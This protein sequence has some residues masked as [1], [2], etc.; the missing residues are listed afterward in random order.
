MKVAI[1]APTPVPFTRGGAERAWTGLYA[2][3][4]D[5]GHEAEMVKLPVRESTLAEV[6]AGYRAFAALDLDHFDVV[7]SSK[8]P[9]WICPHP[10]HVLWMFHPLRGLYDTYGHFGIPTAPGP[11]QPATAALLDA[12]GQPARR[13][14]VGD[15]LDHLDAAVAALGA[16]H[17]DLALPGPVSRLV[18][19][20]LDRVALDPTEIARHVALSRTV[21]TR[22]DYLPEGVGARVAHAPSDLVPPRPGGG[23]R[24][25]LFTASRLDHPKRLDLLIRAMAHVPGEVPLL[26]G[27]TGPDEAR[28]RAL[29]A[30]DPRIRFVGFVPDAALADLYGGALAVPF[31]PLDEDYGLIAVEAMAAG[32]PVVTC[33]DSGGPAELVTN[34]ADGLVVAPDPVALGRALAALVTDPERAA[35]LGTAAQRRAARISWP[36]VIRTL[37]GPTATGGA[38]NRATTATGGA[39]NGATSAAT[40]SVGP[41]AATAGSGPGGETRLGGHRTRHGDRARVVVTTTFRVADRGHGGQLRSYHLY[42]SLA[43]HADVEIVSLTD[44]GPAGSTVL[45]PG[46]VETAVPI[47]AAQRRAA[48]ERTLAVGLPVSDLT[49]GSE[50]ALTPEY[51]RVLRAATRNA[52]VVILAE[53]YLLPA[54]DE[55]GIALPFVYDAFNVEADLKAEVLPPG[56]AGTAVYDQVVAVERAAAG[57]AAAITACSRADA[58]A[59]AAAV[60]RP[61]TDARVVPNGTDCAALR[62]PSPGA[63][64]RRGEQWVA[65]YRSLDPRAGEV[66]SLAVFFGSWHP[67]NLVAAEIL[68]ELAAGVPEVLLVLGGRHGDAFANRPAPP[69][70]VFVGVVADRERDVLLR[71]AHVA[72]NPMMSGSGTNLKVIEYL[73]AG[74]PVVTT[75]V[76]ARGIDVVDGKHL[77]VV[78]PSHLA[79]AIRAVV[80]D[81]TAAAQRAAAG[82]DLVERHYDWPG[83]GDSLAAVVDAIRRR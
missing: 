12:V 48:E 26:I 60:G 38:T 18:V 59:L 43:R 13:S 1:V 81:P 53:P 58:E 83:L 2:A 15:V 36:S 32:T 16:D 69:N 45:G 78:S 11:V 73:A 76:G 55:A 20:W 21:A 61:G 40:G 34:G 19:R 41:R 5:A 37:L 28:L 74:A 62:R 4:L 72:L 7:I 56:A 75:E 17:P 57:R 33:T 50:I 54:L 27:G 22:A 64:R 66:T 8:Y 3:L 47:S 25:H 71:A 67:P 80:A 23:P 39:T 6:A 82:R 46:F 24:S 68:I 29:A 79:R 51:L 70:V 52:D 30:G 14:A 42:G 77:L 49:A 35:R 9:A 44:G 10:R 63:R 65:R 31:V